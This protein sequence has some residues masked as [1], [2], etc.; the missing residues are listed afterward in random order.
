MEA[1]VEDLSS[2]DGESVDVIPET[3]SIKEAMTNLKNGLVKEK[4]GD[5]GT[6][7]SKSKEVE[8]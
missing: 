7:N 5:R 4:K 8:G 2:S 3:L 1:L 6:R